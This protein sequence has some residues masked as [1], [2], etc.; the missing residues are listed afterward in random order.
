MSDR[1]KVVQ[2]I[3]T[4][5]D[6]G[7]ETL[8]K[9]YALLCDKEKV[10][11][12]IVTWSEPLGSANERVLKEANIPVLFLGEECDVNHTPSP[13][14]QSLPLSVELQTWICIST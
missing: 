6:G 11:M 12:R 8:V 13:S 7:A 10:D 3:T 1:V 9:D 2:L 5:A 14:Y 4:M